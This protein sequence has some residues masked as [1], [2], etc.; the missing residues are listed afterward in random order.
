MNESFDH[1]D[2]MA[3]V[4]VLAESEDMESEGTDFEES[5]VSSPIVVDR[6]G[7]SG[8]QQYTDP[9]KEFLPPIDVLRSRE[10]KWLDMCRNWDYWSTTGI[11]KLRERCRKGIPDSMRGE[12]WQRL[13][14]SATTKFEQTKA[15]IAEPIELQD[16][17]VSPLR[18]FFGSSSRL[19]GSRSLPTV[20][21][22]SP[23]TGRS[24][25]LEASL[26]Y[27][28]EFLYHRQAVPPRSL[29][30]LIPH[31]A[32][33]NAPSS[34]SVRRT[35]FSRHKASNQFKSFRK[36]SSLFRLN[37]ITATVSTVAVDSVASADTGNEASVLQLM[38]TE[39]TDA[40]NFFQR[41]EALVSPEG[42]GERSRTYS[43]ALP[44]AAYLGIAISNNNGGE[45]GGGDEGGG[46]GRGGG[47]KPSDSTTTTTSTGVS[48]DAYSLTNSS[49]FFSVAESSAESLRASGAADSSLNS[50]ALALHSRL[51]LDDGCGGEASPISSRFSTLS[52][53]NRSSDG[54]DVDADNTGDSSSPPL[55][56]LMLRDQHI[57]GASSAAAAKEREATLVAPA[58][59]SPP[60]PYVLYASYAA[61][62]GDPATC[63][64][65]RK[66]IHRQFPFHELFCSKN[67]CGRESL[68]SILKAYTIRHPN[69]GYCQ[70]QA[71]L[72]AVLLM[73]MPEVEAFWT[74]TEICE[75]YLVSYYDEGLEL[76]QIDGQILYG[77]LKRLFPQI[78]KFLMKH[79]AEPIMLVVEWFMCVY[80]RTLPWASALRVLDM[81]FCEGKIIIFKVG[82]LLLYRCFNSSTFRKSCSGIDEILLQVQT[83]PSQLDNPEEL[84][85]DILQIRID[86]RQVA[87]EVMKQSQRWRA[88]MSGILEKSNER[89]AFR[90][91]PHYPP[92]WVK[93]WVHGCAFVNL[94]WYDRQRLRH[95]TQLI[96][97]SFSHFSLLYFFVCVASS[98]H[99][100]W[101]LFFF[102]LHFLT[103][104]PPGVASSYTCFVLPLYW[105]MWVGFFATKFISRDHFATCCYQR[106]FL[107][108]SDLLF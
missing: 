55:S 106:F 91:A 63:D 27:I 95:L 94:T 71:P 37:S 15:Y 2:V 76:V 86:R 103:N 14:G 77:L 92:V 32:V 5:E 46:G 7:F 43:A 21:T 90:P 40:S 75:R 72:A 50:P 74:F 13:V 1:L 52:S 42:S 89:D 57:L 67:S 53:T 68:F 22:N 64:Q 60:D 25:V 33:P 28:P 79:G 107:L 85:H 69:K 38:D 96:L 39:E 36:F 19:S 101:L 84:I 80:T 59:S 23:S 30:P 12:A 99:L 41:G 44:S 6:Y 16:R 97:A 108:W 54:I 35:N 10:M 73:F 47:P 78:H 11:K 24:R 81:F 102:F 18:R 98:P 62:E 26:F 45:A 100:A 88:R 82:L 9:T 20:V 34:P 66:D 104:A 105:L 4:P 61:R 48:M 58:S 49:N 31:S 70:G 83:V 51:F 65:I 17:A 8:G 87:R 3:R 93:E 29:P 56:L